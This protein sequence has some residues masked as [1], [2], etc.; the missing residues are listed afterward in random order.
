MNPID[1]YREA[2]SYRTEVVEREK[3]RKERKKIQELEK[4]Y[5]FVS[6]ELL[7]AILDP[8]ATTDG[9]IEIQL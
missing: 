3:K 9:E 8:K 6:L 4:A 2:I 5:C 1:R 7:E